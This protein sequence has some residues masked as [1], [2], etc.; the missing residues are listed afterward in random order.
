[1]NHN[2]TEQDLI[3]QL[4]N[5]LPKNKIDEAKITKQIRNDIERFYKLRSEVLH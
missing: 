2:I 1:M 4:L 5:L 3:A